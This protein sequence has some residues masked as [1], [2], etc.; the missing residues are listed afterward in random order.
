MFGGGLAESQQRKV[1]L[2]G[3]EPSMVKT[4]I[5]YGYT[6]EVVITRQNVQSLL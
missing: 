6:S 2:N 4:L 5:D 3:V 1:S